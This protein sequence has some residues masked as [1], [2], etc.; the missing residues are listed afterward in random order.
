M[1]V[2]IAVAG[3]GGVVDRTQIPLNVQNDQNPEITFIIKDKQFSDYAPSV[4]V[5]EVQV[6]SLNYYWKLSR[7]PRIAIFFFIS[8]LTILLNISLFNPCL[9]EVSWIIISPFPVISQCML[10]F[11]PF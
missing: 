4:W 8:R 7:T 5:R 10:I 2:I 9:S 3:C 6:S 1:G 11:S